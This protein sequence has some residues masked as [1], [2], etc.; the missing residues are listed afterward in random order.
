MAALLRVVGIVMQH[1]SLNGRHCGAKSGVFAPK[2]FR[3]E[4]DRPSGLI[5][6]PNLSRNIGGQAKKRHR[7]VR[8]LCGDYAWTVR[9]RRAALSASSTVPRDRRTYP[10][11]AK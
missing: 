5:Y 1:M 11:S 9:A 3:G 4:T 10:S 7:I 2:A 8:T 6:L